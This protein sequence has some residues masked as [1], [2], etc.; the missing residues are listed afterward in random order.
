[1]KIIDNNSYIA[2]MKADKYR[3]IIFR[4]CDM[5]ERNHGIKSTLELVNDNYYAALY[6][7]IVFPKNPANPK[8]NPNYPECDSYIAACHIIRNRNWYNAAKFNKEN[9][10]TWHKLFNI[11]FTHNIEPGFK[12]IARSSNGLFETDTW[13]SLN[14]LNVA[15]DIG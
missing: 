1:M 11:I 9:P 15:L 4:F 13:H 2:N 8:S 3:D 12:F 6:L 7:K 14:E 5:L 10:A